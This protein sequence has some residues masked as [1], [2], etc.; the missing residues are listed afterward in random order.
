MGLFKRFFLK[1]LKKHLLQHLLM[2]HP[3]Y[4]FMKGVDCELLYSNLQIALS[5][6]IY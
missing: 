4:Y 2:N 5:A 3:V 6:V 1:K